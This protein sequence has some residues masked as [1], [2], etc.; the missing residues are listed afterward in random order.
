MAVS[1]I[2]ADESVRLSKAD[3]IQ[4]YP[5]QTERQGRPD[6][7]EYAGPPGDSIPHQRQQVSGKV[8]R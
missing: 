2:V 8:V 3:E 5:V 6:S 4:T 1:A 7:I